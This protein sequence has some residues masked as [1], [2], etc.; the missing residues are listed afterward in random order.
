M[1]ELK[2][3]VNDQSVT[4][5]LEANTIDKSVHAFSTR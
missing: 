3:K 4:A 1:A 5:F 2:T